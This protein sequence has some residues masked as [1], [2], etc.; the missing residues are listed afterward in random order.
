MSG[1]NVVNREPHGTVCP[2]LRVVRVPAV[3]GHVHGTALVEATRLAHR[4]HD[5]W[6]GLHLLTILRC[7][8]A[9]SEYKTTRECDDQEQ[10]TATKHG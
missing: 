10:V 4:R 9:R 6:R 5:T 1:P 3:R 2:T 8:N 7:R